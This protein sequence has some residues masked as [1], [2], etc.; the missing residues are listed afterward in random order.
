M[1]RPCFTRMERDNF[2]QLLAEANLADAYRS[3]Y[4]D[5]QAV[6]F[7]GNY[8]NMKIG[9][10]LDYF[11]I[12]RSFLPSLVASDILTNF[13]TGQSV[14]IILDFTPGVPGHRLV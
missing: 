10:R 14:P 1:N 13:G 6:T 3:V 8:R 9:N 5:E 11:L 7:Y 12:S 2:N 4:C